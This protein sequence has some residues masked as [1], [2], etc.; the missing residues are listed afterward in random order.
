MFISGGGG[1]RCCVIVMR[2]AVLLNVQTE[3]QSVFLGIIPPLAESYFY[4]HIS[5]AKPTS[6]GYNSYAAAHP[7]SSAHLCEIEK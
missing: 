1:Q 3:R 7:S 2:A 6:A 4:I 5:V